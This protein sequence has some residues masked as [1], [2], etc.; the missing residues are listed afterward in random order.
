MVRKGLRLIAGFGL[1]CGLVLVLSGVSRAEGTPGVAAGG[2]H[3]VVLLADGTVKAWGDNSSGQLGNG[4]TVSSSTPISVSGLGGPAIAVAAGTSHSVALMADGTV[5]TW[6]Y[7]N[8]GQLGN[9]TTTSSTTPV[10][11]TGLGGTVIAVAAGG[12]HT[13]ALLADGT[14]KAWGYNNY[15][16]LGNGTNSS[17]ATPV[18]VSSLGGLVTAIAAGGSH[19][20]ALL[21]DGTLK[22]WGYNNAGQL[23]N[24][25]TTSSSS[26]VV[27]T[28]LAGVV[29]A[30][31]AGTS[32]SIAQ[33]ADG[34]AKAWGLNTNGQLGIGTTANKSTPVTVSSFGGQLVT[35]KAGAYHSV[36]LLTDGTVKAWGNNSLY[37]LGNG[38]TANSTT[39]LTVPGLQGAAVALAA[40]GNHSIQLLADGTVRAWG[41]NTQGQLGNGSR[42]AN[43]W[44]VTGIN[45][46]NVAIAIAAGDAHSLTIL[47]DGTLKSWGYNIFGQLGNGTTASSAVPLTIAGLGGPASVIAGGSNF[48]VAVLSDGTVASWGVNAYGQLGNGTTTNS[49]TPVV[50]SG[51]GGPAVAVAAGTYHTVALLAD[52]TVKAWG[53]NGS[54]QLGNG[55]YTSS[56]VPVTVTGLGGT[57]TAIAAGYNFTL[58][59]LADGSVKAWGLNG[60]GQLGN[61]G[62]TT[63]PTPVTVTSLGGTA[64]ALAAGAYHAVALLSDGTL[65]SWGNNNS[66]QLGTGNTVGSATP[67]TVSSLGGVVTTIAAGDSHTLALLAD[68][69]LKSWGDNS[70]GQLG[71]G[72]TISSLLPVVVTGLAGTVTAIA[73]GD[74]HT[75]ALLADGTLQ[76][77]GQNGHGQ[78]GDGKGPVI[79]QSVPINLDNVPPAVVADPLGGAYSGGLQ[80]TLSCSDGFSGCRG[81]YFTDDGSTPTWPVSGSTQLYQAPLAIAETTGIRYLAVDLAGNVSAVTVQEYA[82][83]VTSRLLTVTFAGDGSGTVR[84]SSGGSC[85]S[86]CS[87]S[88]ANGASVTLVPTAGSGSHFVSWS[89]CDSVA[90][91]VCTVLMATA[92]TVEATYTAY[93]SSGTIAIAGGAYHSLAVRADGTVLTWGDNNQ[94]QLGT[95]TTT[96]SLVP[97]AAT[98]LGGPVTAIAAGAYHSVALLADGTVQAWGDNGYGQ[99]GDGSMT[100]SLVPVTV[101]GLGGPVVA[102]AAGTFHTLALLAD[103]TIKAWGDNSQ[104]QLGN[105]TTVGSPV[106][107][108]VTGLGVQPVAIAA[109]GSNSLALL[110]D[111]TVK[112]W[113]YNN[114]GQLGNGS[115]VNSSVP[116]TVIDLGGPAVAVANGYYHAA[117]LLADGTVRTWGNNV[118]GQLGNGTTANS[119][120]PVTVIGLGGVVAIGTGGAQNHTVALLADGTVRS[121][122]HN[123]YGQ[124]GNG[125]F[126]NSSLPVTVT[127]LS[128]ASAIAVGVN[129]SLTL[130]TDGT[131]RAWGWNFTGQLG[132]GTS[133]NSATP[134]TTR[135]AV[136]SC[137]AKIGTSCYTTITAAYGAAA[138]GT[139]I[140]VRGVTFAENLDADRQIS[141][142]IKGGYAADF[143]AP[144]GVTSV[145]GLMVTAG[146]LVAEELTVQ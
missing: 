74:Y 118:Y 86:G 102:I 63:S 32:H 89:G 124:L 138:D 23:G 56:S 71:N 41:D 66:G 125:T 42:S 5:K 30:I 8:Y 139:T 1:L 126:I 119:P 97:V 83:S 112:S 37:Q 45:L 144:E 95:G 12:N 100:S 98:G 137:N 26:P 80:V 57:V 52:G 76:S 15:G 3:T 114:Y 88:I 133:T 51:L 113:G 70:V 127:G 68:G 55:T 105:G 11:V 27:V 146:T 141:V 99:L 140:L 67:V 93:P 35:I 44:P 77:W 13:A 40:G 53:N 96:S 48:S 50:V 108:T 106:P 117:A 142:T 73:A 79:P 136:V 2:S 107:V 132:N 17:S 72:T 87:Q 25:T 59:L 22:C 81:I 19:T 7:N 29:A 116:V 111:G 4:T 31:A 18:A 122:G 6:G 130:S 10:T 43:P 36:A 33:M 78:L 21:A 129:H 109:A 54:G 115:T 62:Y 24:G 91:Y 82:I 145:A 47:S 61:G 143:I 123:A 104:G 120:L 94:G 110:A 84:L 9:N 28:G 103:G 38:T 46:G 16:Q 131:V 135:G 69:T 65:R 49:P 121:W 85:S 90:G 75:V 64:T 39:P 101:T 58:A 14:L 92:K 134:V 20:M 60:S 34:T 128:D